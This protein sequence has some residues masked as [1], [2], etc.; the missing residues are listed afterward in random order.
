MR[1]SRSRVTRQTTRRGRRRQ[2]ARRARR[3]RRRPPRPDQ[4][5]HMLAGATIVDPAATWIEP[6]VELEPDSDD[7]PVHR[8]TRQHRVDRA[9]R[10]ARTSS[11]STRRSG[12]AR[13][14][15]HSVTFAPEPCWSRRKGRHVRGDEELTIGDGRRC[16]ICRTSATRRSARGPTS[17]PARSRPTTRTSPGSRRGGR[18]SAATSRRRPECLR[19]SRRDRRRRL[20]G[21]GSAI[22]DGRAAGVARGRAARQETKEGYVRKKREQADD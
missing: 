8:L 15:A 12:R 3:R 16:R 14:S 2:H 21:A 22:T 1:A 7:P 5:G 4:R 11:P 13:S 9:P 18:K 20:D 17:P 10:S 19:R 6:D